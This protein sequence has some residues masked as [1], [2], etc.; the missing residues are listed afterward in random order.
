[1]KPRS[2]RGRLLDSEGVIPF[3]ALAEDL[4]NAQDGMAAVSPRM[5]P[6]FRIVY[7]GVGGQVMARSFTLFVKALSVLRKRL[8]DSCRGI[9]I[10]LFGTMLGWKPGEARG[11][12]DIAAKWDVGDLVTEEPRRISYRRSLELLL[13]S[14]GVLVLG[15]DDAGYI[16]SKLFSYALSAKPLLAIVHRDGPAFAELQR[17]PILGHALWFSQ[18]EDM[19]TEDAAKILEVFLREVAERRVFDRGTTLVPHLAP[20][21]AQRHI[22]LF[23]SCL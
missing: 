20:A 5:G 9:Q 19:L 2:R 7:V 10:E 21:M 15:V 23:E 13:Q 8:P 1:M 11:L 3:S 14:D 18:D 12:A 16:P 17:S 6:P 22:D 4:R